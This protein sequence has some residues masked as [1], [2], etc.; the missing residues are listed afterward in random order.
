MTTPSIQI[1]IEF[2]FLSSLITKCLLTAMA[3]PL[4]LRP[5]QCGFQLPLA[6]QN[7]YYV[8]GTI[9]GMTDVLLGKLLIERWDIFI[10]SHAGMKENSEQK[11]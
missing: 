11:V 5:L 3:K 8:C 9:V 4:Y 6:F 10:N 7:T 2:V 1:L